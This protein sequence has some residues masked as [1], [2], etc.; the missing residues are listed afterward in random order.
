VAFV[1]S[2]SEKQNKFDKKAEDKK[3]KEKNHGEHLKELSNR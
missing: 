2:L 1:I 3:I